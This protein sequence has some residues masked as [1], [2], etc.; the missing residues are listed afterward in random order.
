LHGHALVLRSLPLVYA[1]FCTFRAIQ[2]KVP[3]K[4]GIS[5]TGK[6]EYAHKWLRYQYTGNFVSHCADAFEV[7]QEEDEQ[8]AL[9]MLQMG[10]A[11]FQSRQGMAD[12]LCSVLPP[13]KTSSYVWGNLRSCPFDAVLSLDN[14]IGLLGVHKAVLQSFSLYFRVLWNQ[15]DFQEGVHCICTVGDVEEYVLHA[16]VEWMYTKDSERIITLDSVVGLYELADRWL[17]DT[18][19]KDCS[20]FVM[21]HRNEFD[22]VDFQLWEESE[23]EREKLV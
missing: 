14:G 18:L 11:S 19:R 15:S 5:F 13:P 7:T 23:N 12:A 3:T 16:A 4:L 6:F 20:N 8:K 1:S 21:A 22:P 17:M 9:L 2:T 10:I